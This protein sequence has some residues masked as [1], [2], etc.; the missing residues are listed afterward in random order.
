MKRMER[1]ESHLLNQITSLDRRVDA[2]LNGF[3]Q[4]RQETRNDRKRSRDGRPVCFSCDLSGHYQNSCPQRGNRERQPAPR[5]ALPAPDT[6][7]WSTGFQARL[8]AG[9]TPTTTTEPCRCF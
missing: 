9:F 2:H 4:R 6:S 5:Y 1:V 3:A 8:N 7:R